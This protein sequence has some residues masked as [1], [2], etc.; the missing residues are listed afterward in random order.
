MKTYRVIFLKMV[1]VSFKLGV[2]KMSSSVTKTGLD[3]YQV[4]QY[5]P[6]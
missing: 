3:L 6:L 4:R 1:F 2:F 5:I